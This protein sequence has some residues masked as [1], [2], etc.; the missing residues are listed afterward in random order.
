MEFIDGAVR[1]RGNAKA[2]DVWRMETKL[3][4]LFQEANLG[5]WRSGREVWLCPPDGGAFWGVLVQILLGPRHSVE[6][7]RPTMRHVQL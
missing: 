6:T 2:L 7:K 4:V 3:E 1:L 5:S